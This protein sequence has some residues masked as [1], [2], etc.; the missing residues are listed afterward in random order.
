[1]EARLTTE[2]FE[3]LKGR[4]LAEDP[5]YGQICQ[6]LRALFWD[7]SCN[8]INLR[9]Y[10][11][12]EREAIIHGPPVYRAIKSVA[13]SAIHARQ[14]VRYFSASI[15]RRLH[16]AGFLQDGDETGL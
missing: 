15:T 16:E 6:R 7:D 12:L 3:V 5:K 1:M 11:R 14:P 2:D 8:D 13:A 4:R 10:Q 9:L